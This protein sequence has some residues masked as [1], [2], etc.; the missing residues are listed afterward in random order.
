[1]NWMG[2]VIFVNKT[3]PGSEWNG[4]IDYYIEGETDAWA[5]KVEED[6][7]KVWPSDWEVQ[8]STR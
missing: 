8:Q 1:M 6:W 4:V 2:K 5:H 3:A 7:L